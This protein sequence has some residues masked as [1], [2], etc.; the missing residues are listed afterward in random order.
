[1][2]R[3]HKHN[4]AVFKEL[5]LTEQSKSITGQIHVL[6]MS[7]KANRKLNLSQNKPDPINK[8]IVQLEKM[9]NRLKQIEE[10]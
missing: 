5:T 8:K 1:M 6:E 4:T 7:I 2:N 10:I 9:I 3:R